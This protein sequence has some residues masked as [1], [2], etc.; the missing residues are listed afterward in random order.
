M[1]LF[2][3]LTAAGQVPGNRNI[4]HPHKFTQALPCSGEERFVPL[5]LTG[6]KVASRLSEL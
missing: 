2:L 5:I 3:Q 4:L 6:Q 1:L